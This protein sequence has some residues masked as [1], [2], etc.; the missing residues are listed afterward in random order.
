[1]FPRH[2]AITGFA[3]LIIISDIA[4]ALIGRK[5]GRNRLFTKSWEGTSA[6]IVSAFLVVTVI[7]NLLNAPWTYFAFG[8]I[9]A[10]VAGFAEAASAYLKIDDNFSIP[11]S[12]GLVMW[13]GAFFASS[14]N[15]PYLNLM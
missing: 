12:I 5:F 2:L 10:I 8:F 4:A 1:V 13:A 15:M 6:F 3:V 7:G 11:V 9:G 14:I